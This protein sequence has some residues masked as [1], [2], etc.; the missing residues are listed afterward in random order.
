[1]K[2]AAIVVGKARSGKSTTIREFKSVVK[3]DG[4]HAFNLH[5]RPGYILST[6]F[7]EVPR[8]NI[9]T[10]VKKLSKYYHLLFAC[11]G[12]K[13]SRLHEALK[14]AGFTVKDIEV[15][16]GVSTPRKKAMEIVGFFNSN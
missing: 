3:I 12:K 13:L 1:M 14:K 9:E 5:G 11:R 15:Q 4:D 7:E 16:W 2:T 6:S 10:T 8:R